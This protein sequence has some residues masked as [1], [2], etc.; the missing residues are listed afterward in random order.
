MEINGT[1]IT[2]LS[3]YPYILCHFATAYTNMLCGFVSCMQMVVEGSVVGSAGS[4]GG[5]NVQCTCYTEHS[6]Y[7]L[8]QCLQSLQ[9]TYAHYV[10]LSTTHTLD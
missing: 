2:I 9:F 8:L 7:G 4:V 5:C 10:L 1:T 6:R 3:H